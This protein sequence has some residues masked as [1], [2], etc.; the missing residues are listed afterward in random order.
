LPHSRRPVVAGLAGLAVALS[1]LAVVSTAAP[2]AANPAGTGL[3]ISEVYGGGGNTGATH[4]HDFIELYNP[5]DA[6]IS[7]AGW[8]VQGRAATNTS[9]ATTGANITALSGEVPAGGYYLVQ[10]GAGAGNGVALPAPDATG[11]MGIG[12]GGWQIWLANTTAPLD[13]ADGDVTAGTPNPAIIDL[14]GAATNS[15]SYEKV[16]A[17]EAPAN[18]L[19]AQRTDPEV[20]TDHNANDFNTGA[21]T[22]QNSE[23][24]G[25]ELRATEQADVEAFVGVAISPI[26]LQASGGTTP[27]S[28]EV[29]GLPDGLSETSDGV[30][31]GTPTTAGTST[32]TA[33]VTDSAT[34]TAATD[35]VQFDITVTA[36]PEE[37][38][39][40]EI[41]GTGDASTM[42]GDTVTTEGVVTAKYPGGPS[43]Y[44]GIYVQTAGSGG[45]TDAT[46][47]ASDAIFVF[48]NNS[49]PA[50]VEIGDSV[51]VTGVVSEFQGTTEI[52]PAAGGV[53]EIASLGTATPRATVPGTDCALPGTGCLTG[54]ALNAAREAF[55]GEL[56]QP[57][58][59]YTVTD[60][61]DGSAYNGSSFSSS[62][63]GEVGLAAESDLPLIVPTELI[64]AQATADVAARKAYNDAH[65]MILDD[66]AGVTYWNTQGT[67]QMDQPFP[68]FTPDNQVRVGAAVTFPK[69]VVMEWRNN[70]WKL[71]PQTRVTDDG[72]DRVAF[73]QNRPAEPEDVG[74][75]LKIA[76]FNVLN[77][78]TTLGED[79][80]GCES[81]NDRQGN[82]IAVDSCP[83]N[84]PRGAW[85]DVSFE[86]QQTKIVNAINTIDA[87]IVSVE[88][89]E[90]SLKV[91][92][93]DR[94]EALSALVD[95][96]NA[97][98]GAGTWDY[99]DSP[100]SA[101]DPA[102]IDEQDVIRTGFIYKPAS[103]ETVGAAD[104]LFDVPAFGNAREPF[105]QAFKA[106]GADDADGFAVIVNHFKSKGSGVDDGTGQGLA[107]PDRIA[108]A[109]A[110][111]I[112]ADDFAEA[113]GVDAVFLAGD[114]NAASQEDPMQV[115][116]DDGY[117]GLDV[118]NK[119]SYNFD[120]QAQSLDH[121][122]ANPAAEELVT[123]QDIWEINANE[124]SYN[125]YSRY[126]YNATILY[127]EGP[128][129]ASD[130]NP[131]IIGIDA[132]DAEPVET[133]VSATGGPVSFGTDWTAHV[134]VSPSAATG[135][136]EVLDGT[137]SLGTATL[138]GGSADV[139]I[140]GTALQ[141]GDHTLTVRYLGDAEHAP[142]ESTFN[143][144][145]TPAKADVKLKAD[146]R[147][148]KVVVDKT[149]TRVKIHVSAPGQKVTGR[150]EVTWKGESRTVTLK[151][152]KA[153]V[154]LGKWGSTGQ[155]TVTV[156]YLGTDTLNEATEVVRFQVRAK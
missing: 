103:V 75:D 79:F 105:A 108:Q 39:I 68:W 8:S 155:K 119:W 132:P 80:A 126:N 84:G 9:P 145:V 15:A 44:N 118:E 13:P 2:S 19:S 23:Q 20:D 125:Q 109:E 88:E 25:E 49:Q 116:Y 85:N 58:G 37:F 144:T 123:G 42:V 110:L 5:T 52:T 6:A 90:N 48:G 76:T 112:F 26:T 124:S 120:G 96:L 59:D 146:V 91:D 1:G 33:T 3:V 94:D 101:S 154:Q 38:T 111:S 134:T 133:S 18:A 81:F 40:A 74:G 117:V 47:G 46:P 100:A 127:D 53:V 69:P 121:V 56:F 50:G 67:G 16:T 45:T 139:T 82:P 24:A 135:T 7:V 12:A 36:E 97:D 65:R 137:T 153:T 57:T 115:L 62:F 51:E 66:G 32:V 22:P 131:E 89:I 63:F 35:S 106:V 30:I 78:F 148:N 143:V 61:H 122:L 64:D 87:D 149:K 114:F 41:Q 77:Y 86:R 142:S 83:G 150:V 60:A 156:H 141:Q 138:T 107:N 128:F 14:V 4:T 54:A 28:W 17:N 72:S 95:A 152:G 104:M 98:A 129:S 31:G 92:N 147:P 73:E 99:V 140:S 43:T 113:R 34:P 136:V 151:N 27:Y 10:E 93:H 29:S 21:P 71:Q 11:T 102:N 130:H 70:T 55:E